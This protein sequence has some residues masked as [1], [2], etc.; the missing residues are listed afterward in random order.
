MIRYFFII[1]LFF[2]NYSSAIANK[3]PIIT[4]FQNYIAQF[5]D[6]QLNLIIENKT[7][8]FTQRKSNKL[9]STTIGL[10]KQINGGTT[11]QLANKFG[12]LYKLQIGT[13]N[14]LYFDYKK[15]NI[16]IPLTFKRQVVYP[17]KTCKIIFGRNKIQNGKIIITDDQ[18][19]LE[20]NLLSIIDIKK[21]IKSSYVKVKG[22]SF[23]QQSSILTVVEWSTS[24]PQQILDSTENIFQERVISQRWRRILHG[25]DTSQFFIVQFNSLDPNNGSGEAVI[26]F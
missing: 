20:F 3:Y 21:F 25:S 23:E 13:T 14:N 10:W 15:D 4:P 24:Y 11:L 26:F 5:N 8:I 19:G 2:S 16:L 7:F 12:F 9:L 18:T 6:I 1:F 22:Y 17:P